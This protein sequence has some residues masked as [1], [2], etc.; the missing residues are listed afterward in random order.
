MKKKLFLEKF[1]VKTKSEL[2]EILNNREKYTSDAIETAEIILKDKYYELSD[3][4]QLEIIEQPLKRKSDLKNETKDLIFYSQKSIGI[5]AFIGGPLAAGYLIREN[6]LSLDK[7]DEGKKSLIIGIISTILLFTGIIMIPESI[8]DKIPNQIIPAIYTGIILFIV[9]KI[10]GTILYQHKE[11]GNEFY[12]GWRA[13]GI[14]F[15]SSIVLIIGILGYVYLLP[16]GEEYQKYDTEIAKFTKNETESLVFYDHLETDTNHS[17]LAELEAEVIPK[18]KEN[19]EIVEKA[20]KIANLP[21]ELLQQN[22]VLLEYSKLRLKGFELM[23]K[24]LSEDTDTDKYKQEIEQ[25]HKEIGL[26]LEKLN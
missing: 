15:I 12:S 4:Q 16:D 9:A 11:N 6:Y 20:N 19:I 22:V 14:G 8:M 3:V 17:L 5:A 25:I 10:H 13:A 26:A 21:P 1:K 23:N 7:P 2:L 24:A 18:W